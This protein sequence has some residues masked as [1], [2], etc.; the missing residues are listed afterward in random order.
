MGLLLGEA[1]GERVSPS[2]VGAAVL[3]GADVGWLDDE[4]GA[5]VAAWTTL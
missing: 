4:E 3:V 1:D 5:L 2:V